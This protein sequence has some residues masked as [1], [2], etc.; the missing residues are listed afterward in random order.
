MGA[1]AGAGALHGGGEADGAAGLG[2]RAHVVGPGALVEVD[3]EEVTALVAHQRVDAD[4][5]MP[6]QVILDD[7]PS[8][9]SLARAARRSRGG[10]DSLSTQVETQRDR[11]S[12]THTRLA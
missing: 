1:V 3:G 2:K 9:G 11:G 8:E 10:G 7:Q 5:E 6:L 4:D 12:A